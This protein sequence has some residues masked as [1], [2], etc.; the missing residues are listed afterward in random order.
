VLLCACGGEGG[1]IE[2]ADG[3]APAIALPENL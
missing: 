1:M 3:P 2:G